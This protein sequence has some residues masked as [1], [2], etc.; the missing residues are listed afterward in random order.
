MGKNRIFFARWTPA[1]YW[2]L[3][4]KPVSQDI[5]SICYCLHTGTF[6]LD[7]HDLL[8]AGVPIS[9]SSKYLYLYLEL[10]G[11]TSNHLKP[12]SQRALNRSTTHLNVDADTDAWCEWCNW[13]QSTPFKFQSESQHWSTV[14]IGP[15]QW[16]IQGIRE[17]CAP[18][19]SIFF[20]FMQFL[21]KIMLN[22]RIAPTPRP[23]LAPTR[24]NPTKLAPSLWL[25]Q[26]RVQGSTRDAC[27][28]WSN[29]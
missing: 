27:P 2:S 13:S 3:V 25:R 17:M 5:Q 12:C 18:S 24:P 19:Q 4:S 22:N 16:R 11:S 7:T 1:I 23:K 8:V 10:S 6:R 28:L 29:F 9:I 15:Y 20:I 26:M 14:W 21:E